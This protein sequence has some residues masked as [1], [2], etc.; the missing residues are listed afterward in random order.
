MQVQLDFGISALGGRFHQA[1]RYEG[2]APRDLVRRWAELV[3]GDQAGRDQIRLLSEDAHLLLVSPLGDD[4]IHALWRA[5]AD[6]Y[7]ILPVDG[8]KP[9][10]GRAWLTEILEEI[11]PWVTETVTQHTGGVTSAEPTASTIASLAAGL[12][13]RAEMP[14]EPLPVQAVA[15]AVQH[16]AAAASAPL[17]FRC[18]LHAYSAYYSP[19]RSSAWRSFEELNHSFGYGEF[20]LSTIEYLREE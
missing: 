1:W 12:A 2:P 14:L 5:C 3:S 17:A 9:A 13:P 19:V 16:C 20:M 8:E 15:A 10:R 18:L 6:F 11:R 4:E 7:P